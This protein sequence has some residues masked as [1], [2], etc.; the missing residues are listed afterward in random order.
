ME[1]P[2]LII[3]AFVAGILTFL[4]P[5]TLPLVPGYLA[6][7]SGTAVDKKRIFLNG[8]LYVIGFSG[9][10]IIL[11]SLVG[12]GGALLFQYRGVATQIGGVFVI[13][14]G[15]F[16]LFPNVPAFRPLLAERRVPFVKNLQPGRPVSSFLFGSAFAF[17]WTPCVG[18]IL[19][20][21]L[22]LAA[23]SG[24]LVQGAFLL[25][26]F[27]L[28]LAVPF[29][30][31]ALAVGWASTFFTKIERYLHYASISGGLFLIL[32]GGFMATNNFGL[33]IAWFYRVFNFIN[34]DALLK[35]L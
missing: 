35:Y 8:L 1:F 16:L 14:F 17:G 33:W 20:A 22:T 2:V 6:F 11:G 3:P 32:L 12:L 25:L 18:P 27:S 24:T 34:Y 10:F 29:L 26:V 5:C 7:I 23:F 28:G 19:G 31:V 4:A 15:L 13:L 9:V 21:V 30:T